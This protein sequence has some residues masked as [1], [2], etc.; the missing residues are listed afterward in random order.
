M[1]TKELIKKVFFV[2]I[3]KGMALTLSRLFTHAVTRRYPHKVKRPAMPG[4]RGLHAWSNEKCVGCK[5]CARV[6]PSQCIHITTETDKE[7]KKLIKKQYDIE[8]LRCIFCA[9]CV[10]SCPEGAVALTE[11][12]EYSDY[13]REALY[14]T[15]EKLISNWNKYLSDKKEEEYFRRFWRPMPED[16][17]TPEEQAVFR[18]RG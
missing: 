17:G 16:F 4:F 3:I 6:C 12:Y 9:F 5:L 7:T 15:K 2:E 8:V 1:T 14:M 10:E 13:S 11:H 18:G